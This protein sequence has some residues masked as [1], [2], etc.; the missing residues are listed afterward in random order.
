MNWQLKQRPALALTVFLLLVAVSRAESWQIIAREDGPA[1]GVPGQPTAEHFILWVPTLNDNG[2]VA[3]HSSLSATSIS[4]LNS[5]TIWAGAIN[6]PQLVLREGST[7]PGT[8]EQFEFFEYDPLLNN[9]GQVLINADLTGNFNQRNGLWVG[10]PGNLQLLVRTNTAIAGFSYTIATIHDQSAALSDNGSVAFAGYT[11]GNLSGVWYGAPGNLQALALEDSPVPAGSGLPAGVKFQSV[12]SS[13]ETVAMNSTGKVAFTARLENSSFTIHG[14]SIWTGA[15]G[16]LKVLVREN[17]AAPGLPGRNVFLLGSDPVINS[18]S[19]VAF[20]V[21][22]DD[23]TDALYLGKPGDLDLLIKGN[24]PAPVGSSGVR[25]AQ[26]GTFSQLR[27]SNSGHVGFEGWL[28]G[29][30]VNGTNNYGLFRATTNG[31]DMVAR[32]GNQAPGMQSGA[33]FESFSDYS[34]NPV[35]QMAF[36]GQTTGGGILP[37]EGQGIWAQDST[38]ELQLIAR[39]GD[40]ANPVSGEI[41]RMVDATNPMSLE[42]QGYREIIML[43]FRSGFK[44]LS[45]YGTAWNAD[46]QLAFSATLSGS[47]SSRVLFLTTVGSV[48]GDFDGDGDVDGRDFLA[49]QRVDKTTAGLATWQASYNNGNL[50]AFAAA[51][52]EPTALLLAACGLALLTQGRHFVR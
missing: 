12:A 38:G 16:N 31:V 4:D 3:F 51:V 27:L 34:I 36:M 50:K 7:A 35:G 28:E 6:S 43:D 52:P 29:T 40:W 47:G 45:E 42:R 20:S 46:H 17:A 19:D 10:T 11:S 49:W 18:S 5:A 44:L 2:Q 48:R 26:F 15:P 21:K 22:L 9:V 32:L 37:G 23:F 39:V 1:L 25:F 33:V 24:D 14:N 41:V 30:S 13:I 8:T